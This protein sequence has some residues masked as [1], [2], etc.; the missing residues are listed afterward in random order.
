MDCISNWLICCMVHWTVFERVV[1]RIGVFAVSCIR[2]YLS[3]VHW[4]VL[5]ICICICIC[6]CYILHWIVFEWSAL[7]CIKHLHLH[8]HMLYFALDCN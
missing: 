2:L 8:L 5:S 3:G 1:F 6:I 7:D 4:I